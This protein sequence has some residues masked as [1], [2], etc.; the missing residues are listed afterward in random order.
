[1]P[2]RRPN[3]RAIASQRLLD[4]LL[5][6]DGATQLRLGQPAERLDDLTVRESLDLLQGLPRDQDRRHAPDRDRRGAAEALEACLDHAI[7]L[8]VQA[9]LQDIAGGGVADLR[10]RGASMDL[11]DIPGV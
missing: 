4:R 2:D 9:D 10:R 11:S 3:R 8:D 6:E 7:S 1:M 5:R